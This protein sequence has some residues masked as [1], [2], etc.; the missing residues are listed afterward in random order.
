M[1]IASCVVDTPLMNGNMMFYGVLIQYITIHSLIQQCFCAF[2][3]QCYRKLQSFLQKIQLLYFH[4]NRHTQFFTAIYAIS[5]H[6]KPI[7]TEVYT[8]YHSISQSAVIFSKTGGGGG[9]E[10]CWERSDGRRRHQQVCP[11]SC[12]PLGVRSHFLIKALIV[13][14]EQV[15]SSLVE[16]K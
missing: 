1:R 11:S 14:L 7:F 10:S 3:A 15:K 5:Y 4:S 6:S 9:V 2:C 16:K 8:D 12:H 13:M